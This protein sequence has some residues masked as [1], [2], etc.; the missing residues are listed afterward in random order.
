MGDG[1]TWNTQD[2]ESD[3]A[4]AQT[5]FNKAKEMLGSGN[6]DLLVLDEINIA[7]RYD[8]LDIKDV[9]SGIDSRHERISVILTGRDAQPELLDIA[10]LVTEMQEIK[11]SFQNGIKAQ[12]GIDY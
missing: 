3:T 1:F 5:D 11:H 10:D 9:I 8:Y 2:P 7:L 12:Q 4:A 6:Y